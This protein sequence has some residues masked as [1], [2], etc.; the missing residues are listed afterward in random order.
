MMCQIQKLKWLVL[1]LVCLARVPAFAQATEVQYL[2][3]QGKDDPVKWDFQCTRGHHSG[4]W[5]KIGVPSNWELQG[6]GNY[7]YGFGKEDVEEAGLYRRT[8]AVPA[9]WR[10]RR[11]FIVFDGSM[12]ETE[13]K[14]NG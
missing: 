13:V 4:K 7:S 11:V 6:F 10:Q 9:A 12:T 1:A 14:V 5:T 8:F 2:T 3:G